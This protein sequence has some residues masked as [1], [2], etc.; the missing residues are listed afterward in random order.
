[1]SK[2]I[3]IAANKADLCQDLGI[4]KKISDTVI[5]CSAESELLLR[6]ASKAGLIKY[7]PGDDRFCY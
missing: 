7:F 3:I 6:K 4:L 5:P 1:M 2:P